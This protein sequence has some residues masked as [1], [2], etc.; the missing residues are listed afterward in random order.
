MCLLSLPTIHAPNQNKHKINELKTNKI[1]NPNLKEISPKVYKLLHK[2]NLSTCQPFRRGYPFSLVQI[3]PTVSGCHWLNP[4][5][6]AHKSGLL[7]YHNIIRPSKSP[8]PWTWCRHQGRVV[9]LTRIL[10]KRTQISRICACAQHISIVPTQYSFFYTPQN[11]LLVIFDRISVKIDNNPTELL[12]ASF[13]VPSVFQIYKKR[14]LTSQ[15]IK[16]MRKAYIAGT[17]SQHQIS[18]R[19]S[20]KC[21]SKICCTS[22]P[23]LELLK[24]FS[25]L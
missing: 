11:E 17:S 3:Q 7:T 14:V 21:G 18:L 4:F 22:S 23:N 15:G 5:A 9:L 16:P 20:T 25:Q 12:S 24:G 10:L 2:Y 8:W 19:L 6:G 13:H 1:N